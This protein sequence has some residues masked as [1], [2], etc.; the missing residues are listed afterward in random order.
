MLKSCPKCNKLSDVE[1]RI[2]ICGF[3]FIEN[4]LAQTT[5]DFRQTKREKLKKS[6]IKFSILASFIIFVCV[7]AA[8]LGGFTSFFQS[9]VNDEEKDSLVDVNGSSQKVSPAS[10]FP[11]GRV[12][13][14][15]TAVASGDLI[16]LL[17]G[18]NQEYK[19]RL[20]GID[21]PEPEEDF[22]Q[23]SK[24]NLAALILD[25]NVQINLQK[26]DGGGVLVGK[27]LYEGRNI[28][29][30]QIKS[31]FALNDKNSA[32]ELLE[33]DR[34]LYADA[35]NTARTAGAGL[36]SNTITTLSETPTETPVGPVNAETVAGNKDAPNPEIAPNFPTVASPEVSESR[37]ESS[38]PS[39]F[40]TITP[41][42]SPSPTVTQP[43]PKIAVT[44]TES[45]PANR[46]A[47]ATARCTDGTLSYSLSR[48]GACS[49]HGGVAGWLDGSNTP[50]KAKTTE[51]TYI[52]GSRGGCYYINPNG[53]K[54]YVDQSLCN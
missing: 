48:S 29:F 36:W 17:D 23:Q 26:I 1:T 24:E 34:L 5:P 15:V 32:E 43:T 42:S 27:V 13:G 28:N 51:K 35:E 41:V 46:S 30:E 37:P 2:C 25:K 7:T 52:R 6:V 8:I 50:V 33:D 19:V 22:G 21:A 16:T 49:N 10:R 4:K 44:N 39:D 18:N 38:I 20:G 54:T 12:E 11:K 53:R 9:S 45:K 47:A 3:W 31:G 14:R 40:T